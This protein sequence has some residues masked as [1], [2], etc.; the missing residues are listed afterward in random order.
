MNKIVILSLVACVALADELA[1]NVENSSQN[2]TKNSANAESAAGGGGHS[3][4]MSLNPQRFQR[5]LMIQANIN[6]AQA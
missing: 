2:E 4:L 6:Q 1:P 5:L 3:K